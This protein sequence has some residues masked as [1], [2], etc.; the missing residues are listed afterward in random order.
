MSREIS[1]QS[2]IA[3]HFHEAAWD[4]VEHRH[5]HYW[6]GGGRGS[7]KSSFVSLMLVL[8]LVTHP[9]A[10]AVVM[11]KVGNTI[12]DSVYAQILWAI[13]ALGAARYFKA[14]RSP[15][16][17]TYLPTGQ[18]ILFRGADD[19]L[20]IKSIKAPFGYFGI[21]WYEEL[22]QFAGNE[23]IRSIN[24]SIMRGG[25]AF[26][27][28]YSYNPPKSRDNWVNINILEPKADRFVHS[29][30]YLTVPRQWLSEAFFDDADDL[31][32]CNPRAYEHEYL[33][34]ATGSGGAVFENVA[35]RAI[36]EDEIGRFDRVYRGIDWGWFPDPFAYNAVHFQANERRLVIFDEI[37]GNKLPNHKIE[38]L[39]TRHGVSA[40][41]RIT[42]DSG[43]EGPKSI[44][45]F[46]SR[47]YHM[48]PARKGPGSVEYSMKWL[49]SLTEIVI[50]PERCPNTAKEF[51]SY[52]FDTARDGSFISGYPDRNNHHIDAVRY[53]L[54]EIWSRKGR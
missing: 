11:R 9:R 14:G 23:E 35:C 51:I 52:A 45:D 4:I 46:R 47:G 18:K 42:A 24:Q 19:P 22:D 53:A 43:G 17:L 8:L 2:L 49:Q 20:K 10:H 21:A 13:D 39:L 15:M 48:R 6:F 54:E 3:P 27:M 25:D 50:D 31:R 40:N 32:K 1:F 5:T 29:S 7:T 34:V 28:F 26:W 38:D 44:A 30:S 12:K 36:T 41:D 16:E 37:G 33:G